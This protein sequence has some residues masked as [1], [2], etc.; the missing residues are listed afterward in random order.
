VQTLKS[1]F[2]RRDVLLWLVVFS[3][4]GLVVGVLALPQEWS[5]PVRA[6]GGLAMGFNGALYV[7]GPRMIG[8]DDFDG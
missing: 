2:Q 1:L 5:V 4:F 3:V 7:L 8:G 6:L